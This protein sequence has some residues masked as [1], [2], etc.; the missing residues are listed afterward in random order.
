MTMARADRTAGGAEL[1]CPPPAKATGTEDG[2]GAPLRLLVVVDGFYPS[3]GGA[4]MQARLLCRAFA[5]AGHEVR[6]LAPWLDETRPVRE[7]MD[8]V[9]VERICYP[10]IRRLGAL[11]MCLR[12]AWKLLRERGRYDAVHVHTAENLAAIAGLLRPWLGAS[13]T[14]KISGAYEFDGGILDEQRRTRPLYRLMNRW[15]RRADNIQCISRYTYD[16]LIAAGY[17][18]SRLRM[19]PNAVDLARFH[20]VRRPGDGVARVTYVG[21]LRR[22]KGLSVLVDAWQVLA[23]RSGARLVIAGDGDMRE[24]LVAQVERL[25]LGDS[26]ELAGEIAD[27]PSLLGQTDIYVQPSFVEG[28][29]NSVLEAMAAGLPIVATRVSGNE[30]LVTDGENGLLVP[31]G[32]PRPWRRRSAGSSRTPRSP[33]EWASSRACGSG[34]SRSRPCWR[35]S[36]APTVSRRSLTPRPHRPKN[37]M[38]SAFTVIERLIKS[39]AATPL[40]WRVGARLRGNRGVCVLMYHRITRRGDAFPGTDLDEFVRQMRWLRRTCDPIA[41]E[42]FEAALQAPSPGR[43]PV[44]VTFDDGYRDYCDHAYPVLAE[45]GIPSLVFLAT[46]FIDRGGLIWT[47]AVTWAARRSPRASLTLPWDR[48]VTLPLTC[49]QDRARAARVAKDQ[50]KNVSDA[51][52]EAWQQALF[53]ELGVDPQDGSAGR[54][55]L[56]WA[57]VRATL[58]LT[59]YGGHTHTHPILS[60]VDG[61][62]AEREIRVSHERITAETGAAPRYFAYPNGRAEDFSEETKAILR[63]CGYELAFSTIEGL[64][65]P[66]MDRYAIR[67][68]PTG[69]AR[70]ADYAWLVAGRG[71]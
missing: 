43:P 70:L 66:G 37:P 68:Q 36:S 60:Q 26:I 50:L 48:R 11:V 5:D 4:E 7:M 42:Q 14:V 41:P 62:R 38:R 15:I 2:A 31:P 51:Q 12:F 35:G 44:L 71:V 61:E 55:M 24:E 30:D 1:S 13:L 49:D 34:N 59:R 63:R 25:S 67:R 52:R 45:L 17:P 9:P 64:H 8:G 28:L 47:D 29:P 27:V 21:R 6:V 65:A 46:S 58:G 53:A 20:T 19:I 16:R 57:E 18:A 33:G 56:D 23:A 32:S 69:A 39:A 22:V 54:Q 3:T 10:K 40:A